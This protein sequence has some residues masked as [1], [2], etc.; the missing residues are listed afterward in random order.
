MAYK[1]IS[2][3]PL[4]QEIAR[5]LDQETL[6]ATTGLTLASGTDRVHRVHDT[7]KHIKKA[8][9]LLLVARG[10]LGNRY[11]D[12]SEALRAANRALAPQADAHR[13]LETL[14]AAWREGIVPLRAAGYSAVRVQLE[15]RASSLEKGATADDVAVRIVRL[16]K[17]IRQEVAAANLS[18]V[19]RAAIVREIRD[20]H[21]GAANSRRR[22][23]KHPSVDSFHGWRRPVKREWHLI[24]LVSEITGDQLR[25]N[26]IGWLRSMPALASWTMWTS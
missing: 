4:G 9:S 8:R 21:A 14:A 19:D 20:A 11:A 26:G 6:A 5:L 13:V 1:L 12:A 18:G 23:R 16:L 22:A 25:D 15:L 24:R 17:S 2:G 3:R 7:R 10:Q